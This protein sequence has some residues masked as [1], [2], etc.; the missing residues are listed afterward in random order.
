[1]S[2]AQAPAAGHLPARNNQMKI[3]IAA[4][5]SPCTQRLFDYLAAHEEWLG[6]QHTYTVIHV[7]PGLPHRAA[8]FL[9]GDK[10]GAW[11]EGEAQAVLEPAR[12]FFARREIAARFVHRIGSPASVIAALAQRGRYDLLLMGSHGHGAAAGLALGS[13]ATKVLSLCTTPV[14]LVP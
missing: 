1:L 4:D 11:Y 7:V 13:V 6:P 12:S 8:A 9:D 10:V 3:L 2:S 5:G 14:L